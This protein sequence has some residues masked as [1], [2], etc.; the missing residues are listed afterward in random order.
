MIDQEDQVILPEEKAR[1]EKPELRRLEAGA[2]EG[3]TGGG[4]DNVVFS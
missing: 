4:N 2:A 3:A 1:W